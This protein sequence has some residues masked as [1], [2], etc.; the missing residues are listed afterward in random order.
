MEAQARQ[1]SSF[2]IKGIVGLGVALGLAACSSSTSNAGASTPTAE[3]DKARA[4]VVDRMEKSTESLSAFRENM[5]DS[6]A[7]R[8]QCV[9][10]VPSMARGGLIVGGESGKGFALCKT[11]TGWTP[12]AP[13]SVGGGSVGAQ[14][15]FQSADWLML[16]M[17]E[18]ARLGFLEGNFRIGVDASATAGPVGR[19]R[20][21]SSDVES[22]D[23][24]SYS[25]SRGLFAGA[26]LNGATVKQD[27]DSTRALYGKPTPLRTILEG[28]EPMPNE[29]AAQ[30]LVNLV[31]NEFSGPRVTTE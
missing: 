28:R 8:S 14:I 19:G 9:A 17:S 23:V 2:G 25:R 31:R 26:V 11:T 16:V 1:G 30:R 15:G 13:I 12:P 7:N 20:G 6:V 22:G 29:P 27:E 4:D 24:V 10:I 21:A 5:P 3:S 18:R